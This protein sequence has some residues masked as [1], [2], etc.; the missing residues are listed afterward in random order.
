MSKV[1]VDTT[2]FPKAFPVIY[3]NENKKEQKLLIS[4]DAIARYLAAD[5]TIEEI[6][7]FGLQDYNEGLRMYLQEL[8]ETEYTN[9]KM[10]I[11]VM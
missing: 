10:E 9:H 7:L 5:E 6:S 2:G 4:A 11:E 3:Y 8:L 1:M